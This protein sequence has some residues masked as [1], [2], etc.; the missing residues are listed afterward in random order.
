MNHMKKLVDTF[1]AVLTAICL[2][3]FSASADSLSGGVL[4][5]GLGVVV[6]I[7]A[8]VAI[9]CSLLIRAIQKRRNNKK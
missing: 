8:V 4:V 7:V 1:G 5:V 3:I 9:A 6:L 2:C